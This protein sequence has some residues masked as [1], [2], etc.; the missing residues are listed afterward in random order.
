MEA[1]IGTMNTPKS[2]TNVN[3]KRITTIAATAAHLV[4]AALPGTRR[5]DGDQTAS[6]PRPLDRA[7][8]NIVN[9]PDGPMRLIGV[10]GC[11]DIPTVKALAEAIDDT[12]D[13]TIVH[14][15]LSATLTIP[16]HTIHVIEAVLDRAERRGIRLRVVGLDPDLP[17]IKQPVRR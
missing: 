10:F 16:E 14:I 9:D 4:R 17:A 7:H 1:K 13:M 6:A 5:S 3:R 12:A 2:Q 11:L 8:V 15:D